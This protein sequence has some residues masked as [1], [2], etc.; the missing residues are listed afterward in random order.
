MNR[1]TYDDAPLAGRGRA[2]EAR[3]CNSSIRSGQQAGQPIGAAIAVGTN[4]LLP[5]PQWRYVTASGNATSTRLYV[6]LQSAGDVYVDDI[7]VV[8]G[9]VAEVGVNSVQ[10]GDFESA[11]PGAWTVSP[12]LTA[13]A[14]STA[15]KHSGA[16]SLHVI[17]SAPGTTQGSSIWQD[18]SPALVVGQP[19]TLS[20]G[21]FKA[22]TAGRSPSGSRAAASPRR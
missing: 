16:A 4:S 14:V 18:L 1:V 8:P 22:A 6:Y 7:Q 11:F 19:Y 21:I 2:V 5:P 3:R 9:P 10:N 20:F 15:V 17:S 12:N 13:S